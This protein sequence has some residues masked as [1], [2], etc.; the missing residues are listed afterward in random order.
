MVIILLYRMVTLP[1]VCQFRQVRELS[2]ELEKEASMYFV[3]L[4]ENIR[5]FAFVNF[6]VEQ[7]L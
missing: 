5:P 4:C 2:K 6:I 3:S 1:T 7:Y